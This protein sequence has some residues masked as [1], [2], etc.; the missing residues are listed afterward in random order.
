MRKRDPAPG[1]FRCD[2]GK[3]IPSYY[4]ARLLDRHPVLIGK[5]RNIYLSDNT[6]NIV[7]PTQVPDK[8]LI[9]VRFLPP[10]HMMDMYN[11]Q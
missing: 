5:C 10:D 6:G 1:L 3:F 11:A 8:C 2:P 4:P 7:F 9:P